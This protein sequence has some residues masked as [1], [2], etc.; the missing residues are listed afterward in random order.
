MSLSPKSNRLTPEAVKEFLDKYKK[1]E[2]ARKLL[3]EMGFIDEDGNLT[4]PYRPI[5]DA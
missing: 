5:D 1:P 2:D 3:Q 4:P